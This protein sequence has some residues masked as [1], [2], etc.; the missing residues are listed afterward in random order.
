VVPYEEVEKGGTLE[1][2]MAD[3]PAKT[4][5]APFNLERSREEFPA[6]P[7][8]DG[9][10][11]VFSGQAT[12]TL[13]S[14]D[15]N[16][17]LF[18]STDSTEPHTPYTGPITIDR[19]TDIAARAVDKTGRPSLLAQAS[20]YKRPNNWTVKIDSKYS[21]QYTGGGDEGLVDGIRGSTNF[22]SGE[23]QGYQGQDFVATVDLQKETEIHNVGA[24]FLQVARSWIWMPTHVQFEASDDGV[25]FRPVADMKTDVAV[26]NMDPVKRDYRQAIPTTKARYIRVHADNLGKIP[27][28]HPGAGGDAYIF[29]DEILID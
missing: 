12:I 15:P 9:P 19:N 6:V 7:I 11:R 1:F 27:S 17:Q 18:Y 22:A 14:T 4:T 25:N 21:R 3:Q 29:V 24:G 2:E 16:V 13:K 10:G 28:W 26:E 23:W 20:F 8:I 5:F